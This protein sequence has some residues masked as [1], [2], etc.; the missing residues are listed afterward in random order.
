MNFLFIF[1]LVF[2][3]SDE[4]LNPEANF[5]RL[6]GSEHKEEPDIRINFFEKFRHTLQ[7]DGKTS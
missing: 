5:E 1:D 3:I 6:D 2:A 7:S 4:K